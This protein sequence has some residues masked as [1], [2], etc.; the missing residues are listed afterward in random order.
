MEYPIIDNGLP[1]AFPE[2]PVT[3]PAGSELSLCC[4]GSYG[5]G[6]Y[7]LCM[8]EK[9]TQCDQEVYCDVWVWGVIV[10]DHQWEQW[11]SREEP[12]QDKSRQSALYK[13]RWYRIGGLEGR[14]VVIYN[15]FQNMNSRFLFFEQGLLFFLKFCMY[16]LHT[17]LCMTNIFS[18]SYQSGQGLCSI[19]Q[20]G[21]ATPKMSL[22]N[23][24]RV[25]SLLFQIWG[26]LL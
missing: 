22:T 6:C 25:I 1:I 26:W 24:I 5:L 13:N 20:K 12:A 15:H 14:M 3:P 4:H 21:L 19:I 8:C 16:L 18:H 10:W 23:T 2:S 17:F 11:L 7:Y 9:T